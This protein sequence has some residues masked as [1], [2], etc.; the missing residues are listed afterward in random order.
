MKLT[1]IHVEDEYRE[2]LHLVN[3]VKVALE[4]I[5]FDKYSREVIAEVRVIAHSKQVPH[6]WSVFGIAVNEHTPVEVVY[7][8]VGTEE[9]PEDV[10]EYVAEQ[11]AFIFDVLRPSK[12]HSG[13][14]IRLPNT[15]KSAERIRRP[16]DAAVCFTALQGSNTPDPEVEGVRRIGKESESELDEFL[17]ATLAKW[18]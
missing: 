11:R 16:Q 1:I 12:D 8:F 2:Y 13:Q 15:L 6:K 10:I 7:I 5:I 14:E 9:I 3:V 4:D 18:I 17:C